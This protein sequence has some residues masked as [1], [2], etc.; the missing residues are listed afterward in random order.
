MGVNL[1]MEKDRRQNPR[2]FTYDR[3]TGERRVRQRHVE[4]EHRVS[5]DRRQG[6]RR[7][8]AGK[9]KNKVILKGNSHWT[10]KRPS[11]AK[12]ELHQYLPPS[13]L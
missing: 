5:R 13:K 1:G 12:K 3:R 10:I 11:D 9:R 8:L 4:T 7:A 6:E 2:R